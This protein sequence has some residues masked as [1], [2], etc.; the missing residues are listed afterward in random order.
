[1]FRKDICISCAIDKKKE[2][3]EQARNLDEKD[4]PRQTSVWRLIIIQ[5]RRREASS[6]LFGKRQHCC[7]RVL[8]LSPWY[9]RAKGKR[10]R[11][12]A[13]ITQCVKWYFLSLTDTSEGSLFSILF[14]LQITRRQNVKGRKENSLCVWMIHSNTVWEL[15]EGVESFLDSSVDFGKGHIAI[16]LSIRAKNN[17]SLH[18]SQCQVPSAVIVSHARRERRHKNTEGKRNDFYP[19]KRQ[20]KDVCVVTLVLYDSTQK[21]TLSVT[22]FPHFVP[23][24]SFFHSCSLRSAYSC[25]YLAAMIFTSKCRCV[26]G[27]DNTSFWHDRTRKEQTSERKRQRDCVC[28]WLNTDLCRVSLLDCFM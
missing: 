19:Q 25:F 24:L 7:M 9:Y 15:S 14:L 3:R 16:F 5:K 10:E 6:L 22:H 20:S 1:M 12:E 21:L 27:D 17:K 23:F 13:S 18:L 2:K 28:E 26:C 8:H 11:T 4:E